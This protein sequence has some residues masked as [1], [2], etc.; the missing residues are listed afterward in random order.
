[1]TRTHGAPEGPNSEPGGQIPQSWLRMYAVV[2]EFLAYIAGFGWLGWWLDQRHR[3]EPW[4]LLLG[5]MLGTG[6]G[7]YRLIRE[8][9]RF[10]W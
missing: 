5:L 4:G 1:M 2:F 6:F 8:A 9:K 10:G 7:L 3:W